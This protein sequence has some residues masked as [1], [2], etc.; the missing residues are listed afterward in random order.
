MTSQDSDSTSTQPFT[1]GQARVFTEVSQISQLTRAMRKAGRPVAL[2]PT[3][4]ALHEGHLSLVK[5][6][7]TIPGVTVIVSIF[8]NPLQFAEGEDLDSYPRTLDADVE[9]LKAAGVDAVFAPS[10]REMYPNGPRTTIHPG[11][12]GRILEGE[13]R[14]THFAGVL[15][16]VNKLFTITNCDHAFFGE[17]DYQQLILIQQMVTDLNM[18]VQVHGVP[19]VRE[20]DGL[21]LSSRNIYLSEAERELALT[22]SAALTAGSFVADRGADEVLATARSIF[23]A[24]PDIEIDYLE[25]KGLDLGAAPVEGPARLLVAARV[26]TTRLIDNVGVPLGTG[27]KGLDEQQ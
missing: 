12:A 7:Q 6:A 5:A 1:P 18:Q 13:H 16:V 24:K 10:P 2:V 3:M 19:I 26:G 21:A 11:E 17:K 27:F 22:L 20:A 8:V 9:K 25:L 23:D 15:T 4:G 14:P